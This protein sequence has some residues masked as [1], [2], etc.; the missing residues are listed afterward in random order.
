M[1]NKPT[2]SRNAVKRRLGR[3]SIV[4]FHHTPF[5]LTVTV[6]THDRVCIIPPD[7][8]LGWDFQPDGDNGSFQ[9]LHLT[10]H[11]APNSSKA[12]C[13]HNE[14]V[15]LRT[16]PCLA[17][18]RGS[19]CLP[20]CLVTIAHHDFGGLFSRFMCQV[21]TFFVERSQRLQVYLAVVPRAQIM[22]AHGHSL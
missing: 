10:Q 19:S 22:D 9:N 13:D 15:L 2:F 14:Y 6:I 8:P 1:C 5:F 21:S 7:V 11:S 3:F 4:I 17:S 16:K 18:D 20:V 12:H